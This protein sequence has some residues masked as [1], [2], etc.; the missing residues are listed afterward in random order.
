MKMRSKRRKR[1][2]KLTVVFTGCGQ[3]GIDT[4]VDY[5]KTKVIEFTEEQKKLLTPPKDMKISNVIFE[6]EEGDWG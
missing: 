4:F 6:M 3:V 2:M 5:H 1:I